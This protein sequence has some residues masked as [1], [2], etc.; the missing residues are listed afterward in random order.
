MKWKSDAHLLM[1]EK[2]Y[3]TWKR[4]WHVFYAPQI[5]ATIILVSTHR[6]VPEVDMRKHA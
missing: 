5:A 1:S 3:S 4:I 2:D 6:V